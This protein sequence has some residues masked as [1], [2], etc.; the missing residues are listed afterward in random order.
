[1][2]ERICMRDLNVGEEK[3]EE[4]VSLTEARRDI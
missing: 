3:N 1:M 4:I 2:K